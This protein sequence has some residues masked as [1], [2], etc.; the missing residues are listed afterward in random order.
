MPAC[1]GSYAS[2]DR[3]CDGDRR[4]RDPDE[5]APCFWRDR[6][7]AFQ[8]LME[9]DGRQAAH[10]VEIVMD[11]DKRRYAFAKS[12]RFPERLAEQQV[13]WKILN[14]KAAPRPVEIAPAKR[15][16]S[17]AKRP[18]VAPVNSG[19]ERGK[20]LI[21][22]AV[23]L[24]KKSAGL[25]PIHRAGAARDGEYYLVNRV[26][27]SSVYR[28]RSPGRDK[29]V[30]AV[31]PRARGGVVEVRLAVDLDAFLSVASVP[32]QRALKPEPYRDGAFRVRVL[33]VDRA[34]LAMV[35]EVIGKLL[36]QGVFE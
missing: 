21:K 6:C 27:Y 17:P 8:K 33:G 18:G 24:V 32:I 30:F 12:E 9:G 5:K 2:L 36:R 34:G 4:S 13:R 23:A 16:G 7:V 29:A 28:R 3:E 26:A 20:E 10:F 14:G 25:P 19:G 15:A 1:L 11:A 22:K 31:Y 35:G